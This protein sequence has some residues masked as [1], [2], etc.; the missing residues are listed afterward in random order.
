VRMYYC[1]GDEQ[2]TYQNAIAAE[3]AMLANGAQN[4]EAIN[5]G[6]GMHNDCVFP[7]LIDV[8]N[9]FDSY[10]TYCS[11][12]G[13]ENILEI[14]DMSVYP[15]PFFDRI[16]LDFKVS[17]LINCMIFDSFGNLVL[18]FKNTSPSCSL[19]LSN[20]DPGIYF[21]AIKSK[22]SRQIKRIVKQK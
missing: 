6:N 21:L 18:N 7:S 14:D 9:W 4:V 13:D 3:T 20:L 17:G 22:N 15:T 11:N 8:Y 1:T 10:R 12:V 19:D 2:V 5:M 16:N